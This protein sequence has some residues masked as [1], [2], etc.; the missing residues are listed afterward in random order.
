METLEGGTSWQALETFH[1]IVKI[2]GDS[3][4]PMGYYDA[5]DI[6]YDIGMLVQRGEGEEKP[7]LL[8]APTVGNWEELVEAKFMSIVVA[9]VD[10][11]EKEMGDLL[12]QLKTLADEQGNSELSADI[13]SMMGEFE[14]A[15]TGANSE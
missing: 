12:G 2:E 9:H 15:Q 10:H 7:R 14:A 8:D 13:E 11:L 1:F 6:A 5:R 3:Q 4:M